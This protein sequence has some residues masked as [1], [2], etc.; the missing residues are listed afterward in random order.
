MGPQPVVKGEH[1][2]QPRCHTA[3]HSFQADPSP[4]HAAAAAATAAAAVKGFLQPVR[5]HRIGAVLLQG[6]RAAGACTCGG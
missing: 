6:Q 2:R 4:A 5:L 3:P 1:W